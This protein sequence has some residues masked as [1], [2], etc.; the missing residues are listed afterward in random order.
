MVLT[1]P[2]RL[3]QNMIQ[4]LTPAKFTCCEWP[5]SG[6]YRT[7]NRKSCAS[8]DVNTHHSALRSLLL[9][10]TR[11]IHRVDHFLFSLESVAAFG[12][13]VPKE[14]PSKR[15]I[16]HHFT[17]IKTGGS[18]RCS[19]LKNQCTVPADSYHCALQILHETLNWKHYHHT[20]AFIRIVQQCHYL[21]LLLKDYTDAHGFTVYMLLF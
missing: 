1:E 7:D 13:N 9:H 8:S 5:P 21:F 3:L 16:I 18:R 12:A 4:S 2:G 17:V 15:L 20:S 11:S 6:V 14:H 10:S 19:A